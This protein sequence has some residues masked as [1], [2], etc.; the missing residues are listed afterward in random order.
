MQS[1]R[2]ASRHRKRQD[3]HRDLSSLTNASAVFR[4]LHKMISRIGAQ[5]NNEVERYSALTDVRSSD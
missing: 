1:L 4:S 3:F 2:N 5:T